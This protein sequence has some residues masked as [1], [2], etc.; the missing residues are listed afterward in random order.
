M[1]SRRIEGLM[2]RL[3]L[4]NMV[5][6]DSMGLPGWRKRWSLGLLDQ[7]LSRDCQGRGVLAGAGRLN[8]MH[9][10]LAAEGEACLAAL[11]A[12]MDLGISRVGVEI[13][14]SNLV[15]ALS[16][17]KLIR[18]QEQSFSRSCACFWL[19]ILFLQIF[20]MCPH[21]RNQCAH[22]LARCGPLPNFIQS[23]LDCD[24]ADA[25]LGK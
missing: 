18:H 22:E 6:K 14:S 3:G 1:N 21:F 7:K 9:D 12:A 15:E 25:G 2:W 5:V 17:N 16:S 10:A 4:T 23:L 8:A 11:N 24:L 13:D 20:R 19:C